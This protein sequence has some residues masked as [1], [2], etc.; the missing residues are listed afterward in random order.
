MNG[1]LQLPSS[2]KLFSQIELVLMFGVF[3]MLMN[4]VSSGFSIKYLAQMA[5]ATTLCTS[6]SGVYFIGGWIRSTGTKD[7]KIY[8]IATPSNNAALVQL[9]LTSNPAYGS[10]CLGDSKWAF[11]LKAFTGGSQCNQLKFFI[12]NNALGEKKSCGGSFYKFEEYFGTSNL[13]PTTYSSSGL[14]SDLRYYM[15]VYAYGSS[16]SSASSMDT[17]GFGQELSFQLSGGQVSYSVSSY[18]G[19]LDWSSWWRRQTVSSSSTQYSLVSAGGQSSSS[20]YWDRGVVLTTPAV[21]GFA[22]YSVGRLSTRSPVGASLGLTIAARIAVT[23]GTAS[24]S[25][26][27]LIDNS[28]SSISFTYILTLNTDGTTTTLTHSFTVDST[29]ADTFTGS[30]THPYNGGTND[31]LIL[32]SFSNPNTSSKATARCAVQCLTSTLSGQL[33][34]SYSSSKYQFTG[35]ELTLAVNKT[36]GTGTFVIRDVSVGAAFFLGYPWAGSTAYKVALGLVETTVGAGYTTFWGT[37]CA[38]GYWYNPS[39]ATCVSCPNNCAECDGR[40]DVFICTKCLTGKYLNIQKSTCIDSCTPGDGL[41]ISDTEPKICSKCYIPFCKTCSTLNACSDYFPATELG[42]T[43]YQIVYPEKKIM[44][45]FDRTLN[46]SNPADYLTIQF[47]DTNF[48]STTSD[49]VQL[50]IQNSIRY[51]FL[52]KDLIIQFTYAGEINCNTTVLKLKDSTLPIRFNSNGVVSMFSTDLT[53]PNSNFLNPT[54]TAYST[55]GT[56]L[57]ISLRVMLIIT[58]LILSPAIDSY[59][60]ILSYG[61]LFRLFN[62]V[63][64]SSAHAFLDAF[65]EDLNWPL[66]N[67]IAYIIPST[68]CSSLPLKVKQSYFDCIGVRNLQT[69]LMLLV[70]LG[71]IKFLVM[72]MRLLT[73]NAKEGLMLRVIRIADQRVSKVY[74]VKYFGSSLLFFSLFSCLG[75]YND[76][77]NWTNGSLSIH[78]A[79]LNCMLGIITISVLGWIGLMTTKTYAVMNGTNE[80]QKAGIYHSLFLQS[81]ALEYKK[82]KLAYAFYFGKHLKLFLLG[83]ISYGLYSFG[84]IQVAILSGI[85]LVYFISFITIRPYHSYLR[86]MIQ[87]LVDLLVLLLMLLALMFHPDLGLLTYSKFEIAGKAFTLMLILLFGYVTLMIVLDL[88]VVIKEGWKHYKA[89]RKVSPPKP[90]VIVNDSLNRSQNRFQTPKLKKS[91]RK[92]R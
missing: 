62:Q 89:N 76:V 82:E 85:E 1:N 14:K 12:S 74:L 90:V 53:I 31:Y 51:S 67:Y 73:R 16:L 34:S 52:G 56:I 69:F 23:A 40:K 15:A 36:T 55:L 22:I 50:A 26:Y 87:F 42:R 64:P 10:D 58:I 68:E 84:L 5:D 11:V 21:G 32:L 29:T 45:R 78:S 60:T 80:E 54:V 20:N 59:F 41:F 17:Q 70:Y 24:S 75:I 83:S 72:C 25:S 48:T 35:S 27:S 33:W 86:L 4:L 30:V 44:I 79:V 2:K 38:T 7:V 47:K 37:R 8:T 88:I 43:E 91:K 19:S 77:T 92:P 63:Y 65:L 49:A 39:L 57:N 81:L 18:S 9:D 46:F 3:S 66:G 6:S 28:N 71:L 61:Y 13:N